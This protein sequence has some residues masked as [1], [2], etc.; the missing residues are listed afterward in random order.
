MK[1]FRKIAIYTLAAAL[2]GVSSCESPLKD[3]NLQISTEVIEHY[4][5]LR[6]VDTDGQNVNGVSVALVS[7]DTQD[8]YNMDGY[9][10]FKLTDNLI[11]LGVDPKRTPTANN[12]IRFR[13][14]FTASGYNTQTVPV[15]ITDA[16]AGIQTVVLT[17]PS[18]VPDGAEQVVEN[19]ELGTDG[20]TTAETTVELPSASGAGDMTLTI[21]SGTQFRDE[22]GTV[23][24]GTNVQ[25]V[26]T[27]IDAD[28]EEAVVLLPGGDLRSDEVV[29]EDGSTT[30]GTFSPAAVADI[31]M[32][33]N[34][35][36]V[37]QFSQPLVVSM[38]VPAN[39]VSPITGQPL[40]AGTAFQIFSNSG[41]GVWRFEQNSTVTGSAAAGFRV[42]FAID[43][44]TFF[45]AAEFS[46]VC[47]V[48]RVIN[49]SGDWMS[50]GTTAPILVEALWGGKVIFTGDYSINTTNNSISLMNL[51]L[52]GVTIVV[53]NAAG[54][55]LEQGPLA[56]CG[57]VTSMRLPNP[58][59]ATATTSTLQ[60][61]VRCPGQT[62]VITL[63]PTFQMFYRESGTTEFKYLGS[64]DN[65]FLRT[66]M[67]KTDGTKYDFK[68]IWGERMKIVNDH[69]VNE[70]NTATVGIQPGDIIGTKAGAT[71]L[72][73]LTEECN[74]L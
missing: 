56:A 37:R 40:A 22:N 68:A 28:N 55:I 36:H 32:L 60:L 42:S 38:P 64:V 29:L 54:N 12:P 21:P 19:V 63:L 13:V 41:D 70:D 53:R 74:K 3:F 62:T 23:I 48:A 71:N 20:S 67:L 26:V 49:F 4:V 27:S 18:E 6:V 33:V 17:Q 57:E 30:A 51:P 16:S 31:K 59:D 43:H 45:M 47:V 66:S 35:I 52:T 65:G 15:A 8:I 61:Y 14:Q 46:A 24:T 73:I 50:N 72:A 58:G 11:T 39:Y 34:G 10:D 44:L 2:L 9:K 69:T 25:I 1:R 5:T 7:G